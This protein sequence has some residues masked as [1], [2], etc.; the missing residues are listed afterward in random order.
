MG[1]EYQQFMKAAAERRK[2]IL[3]LNKK[4]LTQGAIAK[5]LGLSRQRVHQIIRQE[6]ERP[7]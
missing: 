7:K 1:T 4:G 3:R 5:Q 2:Q 6:E